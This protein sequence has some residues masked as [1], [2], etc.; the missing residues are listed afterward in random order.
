MTRGARLPRAAYSAAVYP[1]GPPPM[2]MRLRTSVICC[3]SVVW[4]GVESLQV[5]TT[6]GRPLFQYPERRRIDPPG[7][8]RS[9][10]VAMAIVRAAAVFATVGAALLVPAGARADVPACLD[11]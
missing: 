5:K 3:L 11:Q 10:G 4:A 7:W 2:M 9:E 1:A 8:W 6:G